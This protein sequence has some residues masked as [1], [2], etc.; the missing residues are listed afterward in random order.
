MLRAFTVMALLGLVSSR[1]DARLWET[2]AQTEARY[3][4]PLAKFPGEQR[5][6]EE[7]KYR[8]KDFYILVT[9]LNGRS[10]DEKYFRTD[11]K[12]AFSDRDIQFFLKM[13]SDG[14]AWQKSETLPIWTLGGSTVESW[15]AI[16]AYYPKAG[17]TNIP[18]F[19]I[20][21]MTRAKKEMRVP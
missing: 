18:G 7:R 9:F 15:K 17:H 3:G 2:I 11:A 10:D 12:A 4:K 1:A 16:A 21:T 14:K 8:Y 13:T 20:S 6:E 5:G 19:G